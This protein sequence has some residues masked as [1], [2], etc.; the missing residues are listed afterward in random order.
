MEVDL[1]N[2][3]GITVMMMMMILVMIKLIKTK[4]RITQSVFKLEASDFYVLME[5]SCRWSF[6][7]LVLFNSRFTLILPSAL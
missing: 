2:I 3:Y 6:I 5:R 7:P 4:L 1:D